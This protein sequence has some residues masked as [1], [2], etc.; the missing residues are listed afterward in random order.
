MT[1]ALWRIAADT[2]DYGCEDMSGGGAKKLGGRWNAAGTAIVYTSESR[3]LAY[4]ESIVH[5]NAA[6]LPLDRYLVRIDV[7]GDVWA[8]AKKAG[9]ETL[10]GWDALP[11]SRTSI[12]FGANWASGR[13]SALLIVPS[14]IVNEET[15]V[16]INPVHPDAGRL[17]ATKIRKA[18]FDTRIVK[19]AKSG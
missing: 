9:A 10:V 13:S 15:N 5:F 16:L 3:A 18:V 4:L 7:P 11:A 14:V 12:E 1:R 6:D 2:K 8:A 17:I 19:K